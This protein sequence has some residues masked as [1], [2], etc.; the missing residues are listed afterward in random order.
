MGLSLLLRWLHICKDYYC[1][2]DNCVLLIFKM[3]ED[4]LANNIMD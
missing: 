2:S 1:E 3:L 4:T